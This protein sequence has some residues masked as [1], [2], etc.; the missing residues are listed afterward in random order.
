M[1][2]LTVNV[3]GTIANDAVTN[4][5]LANMAQGTVKGRAAAAG[6]G[7]PQDLTADQVSTILD[8]AAD[9]FLRTSAA[10]DEVNA[11]VVDATGA[12]VKIIEANG[13]GVPVRIKGITAGSGVTPSSVS[14]NVRI[15]L[16]FSAAD[17]FWYGGASSTPTEGTI[18]AAGRA[19]LDDADAAAQRV[20]L[21]PSYTGNANKVLS[22]NSGATDVEWTT[23]AGGGNVSDGDILSLGLTFPNGGFGLRDIP[24]NNTLTVAVNENLTADHALRVSVSD[25]DRSISLSG[26]LT[27]SAAATVSGT[28]TGDQDLSGLV[29]K[30][31]NLSDLTNAATARTNL[32]LTSIATTTPGTGVTTA[33]AVNV[34]S[35]GAIVTNGGA[36]GTPSSGNLANCTFPTLNQN[37]TGSAAS[38][39]TARDIQ[40]NLASTS[41]ASFNGTANITPGVTGTLPIG[42]GGTGASDA[43]TARTNLGLAIGTNVQA[44]DAE[45]AAI[46]GL[47]SA[48]NKGIQFTGS[49][50]AQLIDL[51]KP[52]SQSLAAS[53]TFTAG[54]APSGTPNNTYNW[55]Q[56]G[57]LVTYQFTLRYASAGTT[58][59]V[60]TIA[61]P[62][63]MPNPVEQSGLTAGSDNLAPLTIRAT[64]GTSGNA[65]NGSSGSLRRNAGDTAYEFNATIASGTYSTFIIF[66]TYFTA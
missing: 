6:T 62:S 61:L 56:I 52:G 20:T 34:G 36:L 12:D 9:P 38:L 33:L 42:N 1:A 30:A 2:D 7:D 28:N 55:A 23:P 66:G 10:V 26:D 46:A 8:S 57:N 32:G 40:T 13:G 22:V 15:D 35:A 65:T 25:A 27:V 37:T 39:T 41:A 58:V 24:N 44:Y 59:T 16:E 60:V 50:T 63:D 19:L 17:R 29:V 48:A 54:A 18:T 64:N 3:T 43:A 21:L 45:L 53:V 4:A 11:N 14:G 49:G 5:K 31:N 51:H 47:T